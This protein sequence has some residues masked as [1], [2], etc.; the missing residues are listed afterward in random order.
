MPSK[1]KQALNEEGWSTCKDPSLMVGYLEDAGCY[2]EFEP[3]FMNCFERIRHELLTPAVLNTPFTFGVEVDELT[4]AA[5]M[6]IDAMLEGLSSL[7]EGGKEWTK[8]SREMR[9]SKAVLAREYHDFGEANRFL[10]AYMIE[11]ADDP[12]VESQTQVNFLRSTYQ[13]PFVP[14]DD[15]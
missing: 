2:L 15:G 1:Y 11:I 7:E 8:L 6:A 9:F 13:F 4:D 14:E 5:R 10:S 3:F 12:T